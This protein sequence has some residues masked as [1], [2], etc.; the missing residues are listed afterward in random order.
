M[1][2]LLAQAGR[3]FLKAFGASLV[4]LMPGVLAATNLDQAYALGVAALFASL[5]AGLKAVQVFVPQISFKELF[6]DNLVVVA[7]WVDAFARA[8]LGAF[9]VSV[10]GFLN[11][12]DFSVAKSAAVAAVVG[13]A[14]A[15]FRAL[16][17]LL[18]N[19]EQ[20]APGTGLKPNP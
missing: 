8:F 3:E 1:V 16:E 14:A 9:V 15:G 20:P 5:A 11:A 17:G 12:P 6:P 7:A 13:A 2:N 4:I 10:L 19:G 18:T